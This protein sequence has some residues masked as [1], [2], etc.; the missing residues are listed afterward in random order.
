MY[1]SEEDKFRDQEADLRA[2]DLELQNSM[3]K[4]SQFLQD[5]EKKKSEAD[6]KQADEKNV[7]NI[8]VF[9]V[10]IEN[11]NTEETDRKE[12]GAVLDIAG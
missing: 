3:I 7:S 4:F 2:S 9:I 8:S 6:K 1:Y 11:R 10:F 5:N 12:E